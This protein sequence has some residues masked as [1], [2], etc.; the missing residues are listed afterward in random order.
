M[1][2]LSADVLVPELGQVV[3]CR[4]RVWAVNDVV[5]SSLPADPV[6]GTRPHH[7]VRM[8]SLEDDGF[9][10]ELTV[11]WE[12]EAGTTIIPHQEL[13]RSV[14]GRLDSPDRLDAFLDAVRWGA[15]ATADSRALQAPFRSGITIED[16][17]LDPVVRALAMPRANLLIADD[18]GLGISP[19]GG[20]VVMRLGGSS[21]P[22]RRVGRG[23]G[24]CAVSTCCTS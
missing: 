16:Y 21:V 19:S 13:P 15:V 5:P 3:R 9:G 22:I 20:R 6:A 14:P 7:L 11:I 12:V 24:C 10:D 17:Q 2:L 23:R 4:D 18:V 8:T 1:T